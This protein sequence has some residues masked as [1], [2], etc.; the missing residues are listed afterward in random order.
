MA[1][2]ICGQVNIP[3]VD[4]TLSSCDIFLNTECIV[5]T[6]KSSFV[7]NRVGGSLNDYLKL[8]D[9]RLNKMNNQIFQLTKT[10]E[11]LQQGMTLPDGIGVFPTT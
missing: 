1:K 11:I 8:L 3:E 2:K 4:E 9:D 7:K 6:Y 10:V 5:V